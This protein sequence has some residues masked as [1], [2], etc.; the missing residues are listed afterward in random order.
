VAL[1]SLDAMACSHG[2][3]VLFAGFVDVGHCGFEV[4]EDGQTDGVDLWR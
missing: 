2:G 4:L 3:C 1:G